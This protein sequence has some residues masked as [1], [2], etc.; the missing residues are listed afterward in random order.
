[1]RKR[2]GHGH[3]LM[4]SRSIF[5]FNLNQASVHGVFEVKLIFN[6]PTTCTTGLC[7]R[8]SFLRSSSRSDEY[9]INLL[10]LEID[11]TLIGT[12]AINVKELM[13]SRIVR[14]VLSLSLASSS[15]SC[16]IF[17][18][19]SSGPQVWSQK[20]NI[21]HRYPSSISTWNIKLIWPTL[22]NG[23]KCS[24]FLYLLFVWDQ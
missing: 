1:M 14:H 18:G 16:V 3:L 13:Q 15:L 4:N 11:Y 23:T 24:F 22:F 20:L 9:K 5:I 21:F 8:K 10:S 19:R 6:S 12:F 2:F 7:C 17:C